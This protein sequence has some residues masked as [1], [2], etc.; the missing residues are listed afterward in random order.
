MTPGDPVI[1]SNK[2]D[3]LEGDTVHF[4]CASI[5]GNPAPAITWYR[6]NVPVQ[7]VTTPPTHKFGSTHGYIVSEVDYQDDGAVIKC[8][9]VN[10]AGS[11][12]PNSVTIDVKCEYCFECVRDT[13]QV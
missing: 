7:S 6:N 4:D 2:S 8:E 11:G 9:A 12:T 10:A 5:G 1:Q 13:V 3:L